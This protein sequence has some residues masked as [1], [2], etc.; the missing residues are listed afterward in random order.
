MD[1]GLA[2][3]L[4][5]AAHLSHEDV[6][7]ERRMSDRSG[8]WRGGPRLYASLEFV[9]RPRYVPHLGGQQDREEIVHNTD[10]GEQVQENR[11]NEERV[12][13]DH[14]SRPSVPGNHSCR[15]SS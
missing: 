3:L 7:I 10:Y 14:A 2:N 6:N 11:S 12:D 8:G 15:S 4:E 5:Q 13:F 9:D 1:D